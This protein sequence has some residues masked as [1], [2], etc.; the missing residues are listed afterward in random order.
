MKC[1]ILLFHKMDSFCGPKAPL[2]VQN[3]LH[4]VHRFQLIHASSCY[5]NSLVPTL[6]VSMKQQ[7][8][9]NF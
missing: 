2:I 9:T 4:N 6:S 5:A 7:N 1:D 3:S 8:E